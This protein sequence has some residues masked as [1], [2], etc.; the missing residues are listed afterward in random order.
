[1]F[2]DQSANAFALPSGKIGVHTGLLK[3]TSNQDQLAAVIGHEV[4]HVLAQH[5][6]E[7]MS[8]QMVVSQG[9][10]L[11]GAIAAPQSALGQVAVGALGIGAQYG[12][13]LPYSR[14]HE[15]EADKIGLD[16]MAKAG[17][18][19]RESVELW[20]NMNRAAGGGQ[21][22]EILSTHPSHETRIEDLNNR[23]ADAME[24]FRQAKSL[25][26]NPNCGSP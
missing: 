2:D 7:R 16:L 21:S 15:S 13:I 19:P 6:N 11:V 9:V 10:N 12:V 4:G 3:V 26:K 5:S 14:T 23:M 25:G 1:M 18:D 17:F 24:L 8:T 22:L 20:M